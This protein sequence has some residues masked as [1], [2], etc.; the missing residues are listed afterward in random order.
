M[1]ATEKPEEIQT[2]ESET[3]LGE[4]ALTHTVID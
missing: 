1:N 2:N 3:K 4:K